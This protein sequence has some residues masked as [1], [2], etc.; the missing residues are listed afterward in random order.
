MVNFQGFYSEVLQN[1]FCPF[2]KVLFF[3]LWHKKFHNFSFF[4]FCPI[5]DF[6]V[7]FCNTRGRHM[8]NRMRIFADKIVKHWIMSDDGDMRIF[9]IKKSD[10]IRKILNIF[11]VNFINFVGKSCFDFVK[12]FRNSVKSE[13]GTNGG[14]NNNFFKCRRIIFEKFFQ[15]FDLLFSSWCE[16]AVKIILSENRPIRFG[17]ANESEGFSTSPRPSPIRRGSFL[18]FHILKIREKFLIIRRALKILIK[19][20]SFSLT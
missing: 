10:E 11:I 3:Y 4:E 2:L 18:G 5:L 19:I 9:I 6:K 16:S 12:I 7:D 17:M 20:F 1:V 14:R 13:L 8:Q 15:N